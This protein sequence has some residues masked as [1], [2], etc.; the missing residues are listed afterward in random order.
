MP[1]LYPALTPAEHRSLVG[2]DHDAFEA[3]A[4][5]HGLDPWLG[6]PVQ[7]LS[8]G[9][10]R[11]ACLLLTTVRPVELVVLDEPF[12]GLDP[13]GIEALTAEIGEW[14]GAGCSV[15]VVAHDPPA[16]F[17]GLID[18]TVGIDGP[19]VARAGPR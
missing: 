3:R 2:A 6:T 11:K 5:R 10:V 12:N 14:V 1:A 9:S 19:E 8:T 7:G 17:T 13:R 15:T 4:R 16:A 18:S